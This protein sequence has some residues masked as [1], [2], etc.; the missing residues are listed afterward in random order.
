MEYIYNQRLPLEYTQSKCQYF[1]KRVA[2]YQDVRGF[3][4]SNIFF[5]LRTIESINVSLLI[6]GD[7]RNVQQNCR[8]WTACQPSTT[9]IRDENMV[10][11]ITKVD[12]QPKYD[13]RNG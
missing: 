12:Q 2:N 5:S 13:R 1:E 4:W 11:F 6:I 7:F 9:E 3:C 8:L 10:V